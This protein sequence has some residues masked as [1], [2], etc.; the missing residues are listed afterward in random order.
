[1]EF[2]IE[3][4]KEMS[5][6]QKLIIFDFDGTLADTTATIIATYQSAIKEV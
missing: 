5:M 1:M 6:N 3:N 4:K 2:V